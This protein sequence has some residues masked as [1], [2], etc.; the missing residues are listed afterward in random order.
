[1]YLYNSATHKREEFIPHEPGK[2]SMY[3][4]GPTVYHFA[5][6]GNLRSYIMEDVL[7]KLLR[8]E[9]YDVKRVMNITDVGHLASDADTGEDKMLKGARRENKTVMDI[10][11]FYTD[12]FFA[13]CKK[14]NIKYPDVVQPATG[15][16]GEYIQIITRLIDTGYA[17]LAGGNV[18]FDTSRLERYYVF[19][20]HDE[21]NLAV[22]VREGV[23]EDTN[24]R[25]KNDF[26]LWFTKS[27]FEDQA[28]KWDSPWGVGYP[29]WHIE[30]SCISMKYLGEY[31]D[32]HC[33]GIDNAFPH[34]TNEIAQSEAYLGHPWCKYWM[35]VAHLNTGDG[36]M[37]KSKG[38]FLT[39]SWLEENGYD[40]LEYRFF[41]LQSHY[42]KGLVFSR[43][44]L[45]NAAAAFNKLLKR[46]AAL[47]TDGDVD[48]AEVQTWKDKFLQQVGND[49]NTSLGITALYDVLKAQTNDA[50]KRAILDSF[51]QVLGLDL[52]AKAS[53][54]RAKMR[55]L[56]PLSSAIGVNASEGYM[57]QGEGDPAIDEIVKQRG[58]AKMAKN[59]AEADR[60]RDELKAQGIEVTDVPG[61]AVWKRI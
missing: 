5:H 2:V 10:A 34:H 60:I 37:S 50:T 31:L 48:A 11:R 42:R 35:H 55:D 4:C 14:L 24:K 59:F 28:L 22:G 23:E 8:Y 57:V 9:G 38:E 13:D 30:C 40:P 25:N 46:I 36:K 20:D 49:L 7:E 54:I 17:Y 16:I 47:G 15:M 33:G 1:M 51:D 6:I 44:N 12:A 45:D 19:N 32:I 52:L 56:G 26:V 53:E 18:Y 29:G 61:G 43:E 21:E 41:C 27:K 39:V 3:T 58:E